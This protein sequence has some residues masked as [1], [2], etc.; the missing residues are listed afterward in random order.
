MTALIR[1]AQAHEAPIVATLLDA[2]YGHYTARIGREPAPMLDDYDRRIAAEQ[3][4]VLEEADG[5]IGILVLQAEPDALLL[6]NIAI[7]P[8]R[9]GRGHGRRLIAFAEDQARARGF[10]SIR[11]YTNVLMTANIALYQGLGFV[12][13]G[14]ECGSSWLRVNMAKSL[15]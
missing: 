7:R 15:V 8:D 4:W 2:A 12:E 5:I 14:H 11:L 10:A 6:D 9:Q 3:T 1:A 13:M